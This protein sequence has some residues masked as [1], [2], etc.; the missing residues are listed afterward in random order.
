MACAASATSSRNGNMMRVMVTASSNLPGVSLN[1]EHQRH[2]LRAEHDPEHADAPDHDDQR[3]GN[4][5]RQQRGLLAALRCQILSEYR[6][7]RGR[8]RALGEQIAREVRNREADPERVEDGAG[9]EHRREH[10]FANQAGDRGSCNRNRDDP[11]RTD[12]AV[13]LGSFLVRLLL[14]KSY[15]NFGRIVRGNA[16]S[17]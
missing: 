17:S 13:G 16:Q 8:Q 5:I 4:Q 14:G 7:E 2:Q 10:D 6:D 9:A 12:Y 15:L 1:P 3:R 11:G